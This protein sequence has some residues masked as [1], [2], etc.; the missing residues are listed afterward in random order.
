MAKGRFPRG[1]SQRYCVRRGN[2]PYVRNH[3]RLCRARGVTCNRSG[4]V[5]SLP[6]ALRYLPQSVRRVDVRHRRIDVCG[7]LYCVFQRNGHTACNQSHLSLWFDILPYRR[8]TLRRA[9]TLRSLRI[10]RLRAHR[11]DALPHSNIYA[12]KVRSS[13][14]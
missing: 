13:A 10:P 7:V 1:Q 4:D 2:L 8:A 5:Y 14:N 12:I 11:S 3:I 6:S 9:Q